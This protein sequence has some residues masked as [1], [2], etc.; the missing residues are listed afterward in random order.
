MTGVANGLAAPI[1]LT[2]ATST[3]DTT[4]LQPVG[5]DVINNLPAADPGNVGVSLPSSC[6]GNPACKFMATTLKKAFST[7]ISET[8]QQLCGGDSQCPTQLTTQVN[9]EIKTPGNKVSLPI[10]HVTTNENPKTPDVNP[11][12]QLGQ[13]VAPQFGSLDVDHL[14]IF[15]NQF[16]LTAN[17]TLALG[18]TIDPTTEE[19]F[20]SVGD[21]SMTIAPGG[22]QRLANGRMYKFTGKVDGREVVVTF[23]RQTD[24]L[25]KFVA[26]VH[27]VQLTGAAQPPL[28]T[29]VQIGIGTDIGSDLVTA[30]FF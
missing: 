27:Q 25:W 3:T 16:S 22:F 10:E 29:Q 7:Q 9:I 11:S 28:P 8:V 26:E 18:D 24:K 19:V 14:S 6:T 12:V 1:I 20:V 23:A 5:P 4:S 30:R 17:L 21:F 15:P 2:A 13:N